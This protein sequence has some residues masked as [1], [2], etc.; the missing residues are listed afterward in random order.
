MAILC[1][2]ANDRR[3]C[4]SLHTSF[5]LGLLPDKRNLSGRIWII[6]A[7]LEEQSGVFKLSRERE[8]GAE[9]DRASSSFNFGAESAICAK[10]DHLFEGK[11]GRP[12]SLVNPVTEM[13]ECRLLGGRMPSPMNEVG[14][15]CARTVLARG[16]VNGEA[17]QRNG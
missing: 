11:F 13:V 10:N 6:C 2:W 7:L 3:N 14:L 8:L 9:Y 5:V 16:T 4:S 17:R 15:D 1:W 12:I